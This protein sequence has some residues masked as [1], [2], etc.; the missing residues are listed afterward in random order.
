MADIEIFINTI[1][2]SVLSEALAHFLRQLLDHNIYA[3]FDSTNKLTPKVY[4]D[5]RDR[6]VGFPCRA[7]ERGESWIA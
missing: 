7:L 2:L 4:S 3:T 5:S 1:S 6:A